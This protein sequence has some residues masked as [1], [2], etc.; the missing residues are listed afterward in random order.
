MKIIEVVT[1]IRYQFGKKDIDVIEHYSD[2]YTDESYNEALETLK[3]VHFTITELSNAGL[4]E[5]DSAVEIYTE[6]QLHQEDG[7][8][9]VLEQY[10]VEY[11][12]SSQ[13]WNQ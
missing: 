13:K 2:T 5:K 9:D 1:F 3:A 10:S 11:D 6:L 12:E 8:I 7:E 4:F